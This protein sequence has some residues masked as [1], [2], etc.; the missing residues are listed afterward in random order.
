MIG[1][2]TAALVVAAL[3]TLAGCAADVDAADEP[4]PSLPTD[5]TTSL[6]PAQQDDLRRQLV[7]KLRTTHAVGTVDEVTDSTALGEL[8]GRSYD[9]TLDGVVLGLNVFPNGEATATWIELS[10]SLGGVAVA[11]DVW[12]VSLP[13]SA[14]ERARSIELADELAA[15]LDGVVER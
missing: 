8:G 2:L 13:S 7:T 14:D 15:T 3:L 9:V 10:R 11:G 1:R 4:T 6:T 5:V 12:A